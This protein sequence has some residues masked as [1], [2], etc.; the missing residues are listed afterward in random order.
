MI[1]TDGN[2]ICATTKSELFAFARASGMHTSWYLDKIDHGYFE[3]FGNVRKLIVRTAGVQLLNKA[4]FL[5]KAKAMYSPTEVP[6][7]GTPSVVG[8][9]KYQNWD[10][11]ENRRKNG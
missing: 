9:I 4:D 11:P 5:L 2:R 3:I 10:K 6:T 1:Y 7:P 8:V